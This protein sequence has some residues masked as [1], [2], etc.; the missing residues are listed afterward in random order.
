MLGIKT[1]NYKFRLLLKFK[2]I[3]RKHKNI[4]INTSRED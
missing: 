4:K 3:I 1:P 2:L